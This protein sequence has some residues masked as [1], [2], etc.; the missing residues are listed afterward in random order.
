MAWHFAVVPCDQLFSRA[1]LGRQYREEEC[2]GAW[3]KGGQAWGE[4]SEPFLCIIHVLWYHVHPCK[5]S[6]LAARTW[7]L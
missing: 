6:D 2:V 7:S 5:D 1:E 3:E 4:M